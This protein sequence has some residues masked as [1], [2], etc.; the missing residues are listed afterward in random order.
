M[1]LE[2]LRAQ[3]NPHFLMNTLNT[4]HWLALMN[5]QTEIDSITQSLSHLL[6]Y[7]LDKDNYNT[8]LQR[9][10]NAV[11]EYVHLQKVRYEFTYTQEVQ[12]SVSNLNYPCPKFIL[13]PLIE[14][15]LSHGYREHMDIMIRITILD[16]E[17]EIIVSDTGT[18]M[19][20]SHLE[21]LQETFRSSQILS[22]GSSMQVH[23]HSGKGIGLSYVFG[24]LQLYYHALVD[25]NIESNLN[26]GTTFTIHLPKLKGRGYDVENTDY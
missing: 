15:S 6:S 8:N 13:Q 14:N 26:M 25:I 4:V 21:T 3:I 17:I 7:N 10:L 9:E 23:Q 24:I 22:A 2:K 19:D 5:G 12:P 20:Q 1:Q 11:N 16:S 18:G